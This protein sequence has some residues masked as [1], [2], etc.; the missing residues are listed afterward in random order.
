MQKLSRAHGRI[1]GMQPEAIDA[2]AAGTRFGTGIYPTL[3]CAAP[4]GS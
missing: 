1:V 4:E 3:I 2:S